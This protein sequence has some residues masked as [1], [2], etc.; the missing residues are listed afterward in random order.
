[1]TMRK[2]NASERPIWRARLACPLGQRETRTEMKIDVVD[3]EHD[4]EHA[5]A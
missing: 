3:A 1:M 4:L 5:S 2:T